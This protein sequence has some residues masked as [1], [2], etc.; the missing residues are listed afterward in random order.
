VFPCRNATV[1]SRGSLVEMAPSDALVG[2]KRRSSG[3]PVLQDQ[4][5]DA[6][7]TAL[8]AELAQVGYGKLSIDA[9]ARRAGVG[10]AAIYRRWRDKQDMVVAV[11]SK[12]AL[13]TLDVPDTGTLRG[14]IREFLVKGCASLAH[15]L[16][17][18]IIPDLLAEANRNS[19]F[20]ESLLGAIHD[21]KRASATQ[22]LQRAIDRRELPADTDMEMALGLLAGPLYSG[23]VLVKSPDD[24]EYFDRLTDKVLGALLA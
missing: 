13:A 10:K 6:I 24:D 21:P 7:E 20:A 18:I 22:L 15:P 12:I 1:P 16:S 11:A 19:E 5:T 9:V 17:N 3:G 14:D 8:A 4:V 2:E 23:M